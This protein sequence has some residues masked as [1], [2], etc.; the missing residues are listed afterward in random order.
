MQNAER[1]LHR[2]MPNAYNT[3]LETFSTVIEVFDP[4]L[5]AVRKMEIP[6]LLASDV[7]H[8]LWSKQNGVLWDACIG[9]NP[10][11]CKLYWDLAADEWASNHPVI[12][13][14]GWLRLTY[15]FDVLT[16]FFLALCPHKNVDIC[17]EVFL[18]WAT[19]PM[20]HHP[21][22]CR[23]QGRT[24]SSPPFQSL[25]F[26]SIAVWVFVAIYLWCWGKLVID[27]D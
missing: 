13:P 3:G 4:D 21:C 24:F 7:L 18:H 26:R 6:I 2:W 15:G 19:S 14:F 22:I 23:L 20:H 8:S 17:F 5:A 25:R 12:Q 11:R 27:S 9:A 10:E 16:L 1:D